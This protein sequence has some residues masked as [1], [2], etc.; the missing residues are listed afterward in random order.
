MTTDAVNWVACRRS[1]CMQPGGSECQTPTGRRYDGVHME[2]LAALRTHPDFDPAHYSVGADSV[3]TVADATRRSPKKTKDDDTLYRV[4]WRTSFGDIWRKDN[5]RTS[6]IVLAYL[7]A[8]RITAMMVALRL[9]D[10]Y[11]VN[12]VPERRVPDADHQPCKPSPSAV[13]GAELDT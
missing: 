4:H 6:S 12:V 5:W 9:P 10:G 7:R 2:R 8:G 1:T 3:P 11:Q 13:A